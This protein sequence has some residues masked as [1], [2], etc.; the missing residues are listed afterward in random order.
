MLSS[1]RLKKSAPH[2]FHVCPLNLKLEPEDGEPSLA[3]TLKTGGNETSFSAD[4]CG[5]CFLSYQQNNYPFLFLGR[6]GPSA[7]PLNM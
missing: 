7:N 1:T 2:D 6:S 3:R 5:L 4:T